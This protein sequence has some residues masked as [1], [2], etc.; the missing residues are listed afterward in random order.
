MINIPDTLLLLKARLIFFWE[1]QRKPIFHILYLK[2]KKLEK[3]EKVHFKAFLAFQAF[4]FVFFFL[5]VTFI[6]TFLLTGHCFNQHYN[7]NHNRNEAT[8]I[9]MI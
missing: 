8:I 7:Y 1:N 4:V 6:A 5:Y 3:M 9:A 2:P